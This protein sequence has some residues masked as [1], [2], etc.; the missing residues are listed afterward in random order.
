MTKC[1]TFPL[2]L[3]WYFIF[4]WIPQLK[5]GEE[6][7]LI[8][9]LLPDTQCCCIWLV[10][11]SWSQDR[12]PALLCPS[13]L[14]HRA[15]ALDR[16]EDAQMKNNEMLPFMAVTDKSKEEENVVIIVLFQRQ[17]ELWRDR[18]I[19]EWDLGK[20]ASAFCS[21][22]PCDVGQDIYFFSAPSKA[23]LTAFCHL[24]WRIR[25]ER[26]WGYNNSVNIRWLLI[27]MET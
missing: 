5:V 9:K 15:F 22:F 25:R 17:R 3:P 16:G 13:G 23:R 4:L 19:R 2:P 7:E 27:V 18:R 20:M 11:P 21:A 6:L 26:D 14:W 8:Q 10:S 24:T 12:A 1:L